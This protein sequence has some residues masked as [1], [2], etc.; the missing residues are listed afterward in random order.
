M[1][2]TELYLDIHAEN[3]VLLDSRLSLASLAHCLGKKKPFDGNQ[4]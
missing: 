3:V 4:F 1:E 2:I